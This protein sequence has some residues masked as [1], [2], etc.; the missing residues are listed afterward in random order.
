MDSLTAQPRLSDRHTTIS[1]G[2]I[3]AFPNRSSRMPTFVENGLDDDNFNINVDPPV[4]EG[5]V[6]ANDEQSILSQSETE[7][8]EE[9]ENDDAS[10][11]TEVEIDGDDDDSVVFEALRKEQIKWKDVA[12]PFEH[13][14]ATL[15]EARFQT[16]Q[17]CI[18]EKEYIV[19]RIKEKLNG[20]C[21]KKFSNIMDLIFGS[22]S[23]L[24]KELDGRLN[25]VGND[26]EKMDHAL[27]LKNLV[28]FFLAGAYHESTTSMYSGVSFLDKEKFASKEEYVQF[29]KRMSDCDR[30]SD[31]DEESI[32]LWQGVQDA[33]NKTLRDLFI[34]GVK[35]FV[36]RP[37]VTIDDDKMHYSI[38]NKKGNT[39]GLKLTQHVRDNRK[40][41]VD[42]HI[43]YTAT[44]VPIGVDWE[45]TGDDFAAASSIRLIKGQLCPFQRDARV[46]DLTGW[47][48]LADRNYWTAEFETDFVLASGME[49]E[50]ATHK[51]DPNFGFTFDQK[52]AKKDQRR[53]I[54]QFGEKVRTLYFI[55]SMECMHIFFTAVVSING[56]LFA[57]CFLS[58]A[59]FLR[60]KKVGDRQLTGIAY[61][62]NG[63]VTLGT[64]TQHVDMHWDLV[65][66]NPRDRKN[67]ESPEWR[68][69]SW[70]NPLGTL[71]DADKT[72][73]DIS[74]DIDPVTTVGGQAGWF[75]LR[76]YSIG[77]STADGFIGTLKRC[78]NATKQS[79]E[80]ASLFTAAQPIFEYIEKNLNEDMQ[81]DWVVGGEPEEHADPNT[82]APPAESEEGDLPTTVDP[83]D[84]DLDAALANAINDSPEYVRLIIKKVENEAADD[85]CIQILLEHIER[86]DEMSDEVSKNNVAQ[87]STLLLMNDC[88]RPPNQYHCASFF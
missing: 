39:D 5:G 48:I 32:P 55:F 87:S 53:H 27:F 4:D 14:R 15:D 84:F 76:G 59:M 36:D 34:V 6:E 71:T 77:S 25:G 57:F 16:F 85:A 43:V 70:L 50:A 23:K 80:N 64:S 1:K 9:E 69:R 11:S 19:K 28:T 40:G 52:K 35:E 20:R 60:R 24:W 56:M 3:E 67:S 86:P 62:N 26:G 21:E 8:D 54:P 68:R 2:D 42:N 46:P 66:T 82:E 74:L 22:D 47:G 13:L 88:I 17:L 30:I 81:E 73:L 37:S 38:R 58:K 72:L 12:N 31:D 18:Q 45:K 10:D 75:L 29:W 33:L 78:S 41:F 83:P 7:S 65:L 51:R 79:A 63:A 61:R 49:I 44:G